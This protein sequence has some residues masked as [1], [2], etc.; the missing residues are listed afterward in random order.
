MP[1]FFVWSIPSLIAVVEAANEHDVAA[2]FIGRELTP[3]P[4]LNALPVC[5]VQ[6]VDGEKVPRQDGEIVEF[7]LDLLAPT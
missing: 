6:P 4:T 1:D 5:F 7:W 3:I 2:K